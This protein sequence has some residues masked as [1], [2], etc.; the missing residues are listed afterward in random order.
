MSKYG[1]VLVLSC[2][3]FAFIGCGKPKETDSKG[4]GSTTTVAIDK[5]GD[6]PIGT[7]APVLSDSSWSWRSHW[8]DFEVA[9]P[10]KWILRPNPNVVASFSC[11]QPRAIGMV[12]E[13]GPAATDAE[14]Q[15]ALAFTKGM[16]NDARTSNPIE[17]PGP[18][19]HGLDC[20]LHV[21]DA[22]TNGKPYVFGASITR[23]GNQAV[24]MMFEG[25][26]LSSDEVRRS[27]VAQLLRS[28]A[29]EYLGSVKRTA[30][31]TANKSNEELAKPKLYIAKAAKL[32]EIGNIDQAR[33][34]LL[35]AIRIDPTDAMAH[36]YLGA[37]CVETKDIDDTIDAF[38][39]AIRLQPRLA[40]AYSNRGSSYG[41]QRNFQKAIEDYNEAIRLD[42]SDAKALA[43]RALAYVEIDKPDK[44]LE[45]CT[46]A[47]RLNPRHAVAFFAR[48]KASSRNKDLEKAI[49]D[50]STAIRL[51]PSYYDAYYDR[52][53]AHHVK[54]DFDKAIEDYSQAIRLN[55]ADGASFYSRGVC[56]YYKMEYDKAIKDYD[57]AI[58]LDPQL[59]KSHPDYTRDIKSK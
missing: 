58:R 19:R 31:I 46:E 35:Q 59:K 25:Q 52:G 43:N 8:H 34:Y 3:A 13:I 11:F 50:Y 21:G 27:E 40:N 7:K 10:E 9:L 56:F 1:C 6:A 17:R 29:V 38:G 5:S 32:L 18:N 24:I 55:P 16:K 42:P 48:G 51:N 47:I 33:E 28:Q 49:D 30:H 14:Y 22:E 37:V 41:Q 2:F 36:Y 20:W 23:V 53:A 44:A 26:F 12:A 45:D 39:E 57:Q 15:K 54:R 4:N